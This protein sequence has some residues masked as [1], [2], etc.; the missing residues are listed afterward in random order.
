MPYAMRARVACVCVL[1]R[2][3][4]HARSHAS[5]IHPARVRMPHATVRV[6]HACARDLCASYAHATAFACGR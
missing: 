3:A 2:G 6:R 5:R 1:R 4:W